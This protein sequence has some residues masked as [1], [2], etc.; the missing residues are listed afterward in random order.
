MRGGE[1]EC[2]NDRIG[3]I[4]SQYRLAGAYWPE[5]MGVIMRTIAFS[6]A[7]KL[8]LPPGE[9]LFLSAVHTRV[10]TAAARGE[11]FLN[12]LAREELAHRGLDV[13]G[14]WIGLEPSVIARLQ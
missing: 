11:I 1:A 9:L 14:E 10:L 13:A 7:R 4:P 12:Q 8:D 5:A 2:A 3:D 6:Y